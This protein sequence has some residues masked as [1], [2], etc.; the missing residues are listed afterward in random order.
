MTVILQSLDFDVIALHIVVA[1]ALD[2]EIL[3]QAPL[4]HTSLSLLERSVGD[5]STWKQAST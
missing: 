4:V 3:N 1:E 2:S 5:Y